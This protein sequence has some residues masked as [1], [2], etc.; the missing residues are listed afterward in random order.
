VKGGT[1]KGDASSKKD[2]K[3]SAYNQFMAK[4]LPLYK[5]KHPESNHK[6]NFA[7]VAAQWKTDPANPKA[8]P[9]NSGDAATEPEMQSLVGTAE[10]LIPEEKK[11]KKKKKKSA[12]VQ[13]R[14]RSRLLIP[15]CRD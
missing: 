6:D 2:R 5:A 12:S 15:R 1:A 13:S 3:P 10:S 4:Q 11:K 7:A 8:N 9:K 14:S